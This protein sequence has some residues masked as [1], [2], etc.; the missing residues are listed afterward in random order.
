MKSSVGQNFTQ[1]QNPN[2]VRQF[3]NSYF[4]KP[5]GPY[6]PQGNRF[7]NKGRRPNK[8]WNNN[9]YQGFQRGGFFHQN[10][11][12]N[13]WFPPGFMPPSIHQRS[14]FHAQNFRQN[15][16]YRMQNESRPPAAPQ[17]KKRQNTGQQSQSE[18]PVSTHA[19]RTFNPTYAE[20]TAFNAGSNIPQERSNN[21]QSKN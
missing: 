5:R 3:N 8:K 1:A 7:Y 15:Q 12:N 6:R 20:A 10:Y 19:L 9:G 14:E 13:Q 2:F 17:T 16:D 21:H 11:G 18:R 4:V